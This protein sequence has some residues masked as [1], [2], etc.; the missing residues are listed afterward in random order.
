MREIP[1]LGFLEMGYF[2][3]APGWG[4]GGTPDLGLAALGAWG[5]GGLDMG[6]A[7]GKFIGS[8]I[9]RLDCWVSIVPARVG[10]VVGLW[11]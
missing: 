9:E 4:R 2:F 5:F 6:F 8:P 1:L 10:T 3:V 7:V 11:K